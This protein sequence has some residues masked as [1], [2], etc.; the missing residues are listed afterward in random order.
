[1]ELWI[2]RRLGIICIHCDS[3]PRY[4][5]KLTDKYWVNYSICPEFGY[6]FNFFI[7]DVS[8]LKESEKRF[9]I[10]RKLLMEVK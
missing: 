8:P 6:L 10:T 2:Q 5:R 9:E 4:Y 7:E 3:K 1:M